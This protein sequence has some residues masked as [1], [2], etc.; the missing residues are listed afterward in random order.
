MCALFSVLLGLVCTILRGVHYIEVCSQG[1]VH[2][3]EVC[4]Y[5]GVHYIEVCVRR[6]ALYRGVLGRYYMRWSLGVHYI[7]CC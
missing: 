2:Y 3:I 4:C 5:I 7:V 1:G 6:S